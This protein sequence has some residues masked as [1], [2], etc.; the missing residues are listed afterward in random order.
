MALNKILM[1]ILNDFRKCYLCEDKDVSR[2]FE[3]LINYLVVS[4]FHPEAFR[5]KGD[6]DRVVV[7]QKGQFGLDAIAI[8]VNGNLVLS[9]EDISIYV[10]SNRLDVDIIFI[11]TKASETCETGDLLKTIQATKNFLSNFHAITEK[12][13][14]ICNAQEIYNHIIGEYDNYKYCTTQSPRC[15]VYYVTAAND[16]DKSL[17]GNICDSSQKEIISAVTEI[18]NV[19]TKVLG[20]D[21]I[22]EAYGE[23]KNRIAVKVNLKNCITLDKIDGVNEAYLGYLTG[24]DYLRI[25]CDSNGDIRRHIFYENVR[26]YQGRENSVNKD[27]RSTI[28]SETERGQFILLNNGVTIITKSVTSLGGNQY[29]LSNFQIVNGCQTSYEIYNCKDAAVNIFVPVKIIYTTDNDIISRIVKATNRQSPV[30]EEA[31]ICLNKYHQELQCLFCEYSKEMPLEM[32]YERRSGE[33]DDIKEK[34]GEYQVVTLHGI[35]RAVESVYLQN[36]YMVY[37]TNP[38]NIYRKQK[39]KLFQKD[40]KLEIY[41]IASYLFVKLSSLHQNG[42]LSKKDYTLRFYIIMIVRMLILK[43]FDV[44]K[45][46]SKSMEVENKKMLKKLNADVDKYFIEAK[47]I[48]RKV[49]GEIEVDKRKTYETLRSSEFC[50]KIK[51]EMKKILTS[52]NV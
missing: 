35:I 17:V 1:G 30:P 7:D 6:L 50:K 16:W 48:V 3:S 42:K 14:N 11:Q 5:D 39:D 23:V 49:L 28:T 31:F 27:I 15:H 10:K 36:P 52:K 44:P 41:Y 43:T 22:I 32:F 2:D 26:D 21:Y 13:D 33:E 19:D 4:K 46:C 12:N 37:G 9:K 25:I 20:R 24:E 34:K 47:E 45:F 51:A 38:A 18:K 29:E 8:I 40:Q